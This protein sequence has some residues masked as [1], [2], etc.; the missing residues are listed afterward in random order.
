MKRPFTFEDMPKDLEEKGWPRKSSWEARQFIV[1]VKPWLDHLISKHGR[2]TE[3]LHLD[4]PDDPPDVC[5]IFEDGAI[6]F[7][8]TQLV[9][10]EFAYFDHV[11]SDLRN[12]H[13]TV[14]P[15]L[16]AGKLNREQMISHALDQTGM[17]GWASVEEEARL[18]KIRFESQFRKKVDRARDNKLQY[19]VMYADS[20]HLSTTYTCAVARHLTEIIQNG[21]GSFPSAILFVENS[22]NTYETFLLSKAQPPR[23]RLCRPHQ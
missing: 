3:I 23:R 15:T 12:D 10:Q 21:I 22:Q 8:V 7:E 19:I 9:P 11:V 18:L 17:A 14:S 2:I 1:S 5:V 4:N 20:S 16:S 13:C 6:G